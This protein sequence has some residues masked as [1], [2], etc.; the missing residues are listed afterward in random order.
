[1]NILE[2]YKTNTAMRETYYRMNSI[3]HAEIWDTD[4]GYQV[5]LCSSEGIGLN[6]S[7]EFYTIGQCAK[8]AKE[9][10]PELS[11]IG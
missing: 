3:K 7:P 11:L 5:A 9:F 6:S 2:A 4:D 8:W 10:C 1:M